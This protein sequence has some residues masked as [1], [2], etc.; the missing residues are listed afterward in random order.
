MCVPA[1]AAGVVGVAAVSSRIGQLH[2]SSLAEAAAGKSVARRWQEAKGR[3][4]SVRREERSRAEGGGGGRE[5]EDERAWL[6]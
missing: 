3:L 6:A 4:R 2:S 1:E 5:A